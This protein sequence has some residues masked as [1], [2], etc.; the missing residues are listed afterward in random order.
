MVADPRCG[1]RL[2]VVL[3]AARDLL[4]GSTCVGCAR[5]GRLLCWSCAEGLDPHPA[6]AWPTPRPPG[7]TEP[8]AAMGYDG[9]VRAMLLGHKEHRLLG[10]ARPLGELLAI[11]VAAAIDDLLPSAP[12]PPCCWSPCRRVLARSGSAATSRR[13]SWSGS[14]PVDSPRSAVRPRA[15]RCSAP[16]RAWPTRRGWTP[17]PAHSTWRVRPHP[18]P[19]PASACSRRPTL[20]CGGLRRRA[21]HRSDRRRGPAGAPRGRA[22]TARGGC[23]G[24]D[25]TPWPGVTRHARTVG[26]PG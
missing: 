15:W 21:H 26:V 25:P 11:A 1:D 2:T 6:P 12:W 3:D 14:P 23:G 18:R 17:A 20:P 19:G 22:P 13:R 8:W 24:R 10:L 16:A 4:L 9:T 5:A 7:L